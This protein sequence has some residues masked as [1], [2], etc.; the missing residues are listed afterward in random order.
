M[1]DCIQDLPIFLLCVHS[2]MK[3]FSIRNAYHFWPLLLTDGHFLADLRR[4]F[5]LSYALLRAPFYRPFF[6]YFYT[7]LRP[8]SSPHFF[9]LSAHIEQQRHKKRVMCFGFEATVHFFEVATLCNLNTQ[10]RTAWKYFWDERK[11]PTLKPKILGSIFGTNA[12]YPLLTQRAWT[13]FRSERK[14]YIPK[15]K[16]RESISGTNRKSP[17]PTQAP[18][19]YFWNNRI[20]P[21]SIPLIRRCICM[22]T[23][24]SFHL[25]RISG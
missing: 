6:S 15:P 24:F 21:F 11:I 13:Y 18:G 12:K 1:S 5:C 19:Q 3:E 22:F 14:I 10:T 2:I 9:C 20:S 16:V 23:F 25:P 4:S 8:Y 7:I 17:F